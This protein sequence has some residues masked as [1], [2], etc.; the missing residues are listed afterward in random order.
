[1]VEEPTAH[2]ACGAAAQGVD[3]TS[4]PLAIRNHGVSHVEAHY[5]RGSGCSDVGLLQKGDVEPPPASSCSP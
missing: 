4:L 3:K 2:P 1:M 5:E